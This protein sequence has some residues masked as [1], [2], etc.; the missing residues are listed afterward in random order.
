M[1]KLP[2]H[3]SYSVAKI[4]FGLYL[5]NEL[6][7]SGGKEFPTETDVKKILLRINPNCTAVE[8]Q[9]ARQISRYCQTNRDYLRDARPPLGAAPRTDAK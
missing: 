5:V 3:I 7:A 8:L 9:T 2:R 6:R 1:Q 4:S